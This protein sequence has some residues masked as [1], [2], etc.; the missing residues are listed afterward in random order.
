MKTI[1]KRIIG[2]VVFFAVLLGILLYAGRLVVP[3]E[4]FYN[5][6][7]QYYQEPEDSID[8]VLIGSSALYRYWIPPQAYQQTG[9]TSVPLAGASQPFESAIYILEEAVKTQP[10]AVYVVEVRQLVKKRCLTID[11]TYDPTDPDYAVGRMISGMKPSLTKL[12]AAADLMGQYPLDYRLDWMLPILKFHDNFL[13]FSPMELL[14]RIPAASNPIKYTIQTGKIVAMEASQPQPDG[15]YALTREDMEAVDALARKADAL[16]VRLLFLSTP[17]VMDDATYTVQTQL[18][19]Y[20]A[21]QGYD[22]LNLQESMDEIGLSLD[23]DFYNEYHT[24]VYGA[25]KLTQFLASY[26]AE[27][28]GTSAHSSQVQAQ[29]ESAAANW[30]AQ[31][32]TS[33]AAAADDDTLEEY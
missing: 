27:H 17:Y 7:E 11:G 24:N 6:W 28:Y 15:R 20:M 22:Y 29:W 31:C 8:A 14:E 10:S 16:G 9:L 13:T 18:T 23:T 19:Q 1:F 32:R 2:S 12:R 26:L 4:R 5:L 21:Q 30:Q 3:Q 33:F 25:K